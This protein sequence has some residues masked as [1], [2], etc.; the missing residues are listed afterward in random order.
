MRNVKSSLLLSCLSLLSFFT[1]ANNTGTDL[2]LSMHAVAG[3]MAGAA[4]TKPQEASSAVFGNPA[5]LAQ[6]K[7]VNYDFGA[8][9]LKIDEL[10][11]TQSTTLRGLGPNGSDL[12]FSNSSISSADNYILPTLASA[13][14]INDKAF[15]GLG[16][17]VDAGIGADF[18]NNP[19][20]LLGGAGEALVTSTVSLPLNIE[21]ISMNANVAGAYQVTPKL[22]LGASFTIGF[23]LA[24]F[25]TTG[26][27]QG[28]DELG[29]AL[30]GAVYD[31]GG[32][33][34]S[35][36]DTAFGYS[37]GATY[38]EPS[39]LAFS[40]ALK[41]SVKYKFE[42]I[43]YANT[44]A[45]RGFQDLPVEQPLEGIVGVAFD[46]YFADDLLIEADIIWKNWSSADT[47]QDLY[48]DQYLYVL[49]LQYKN[50]L[51]NLDFRFGYSYAENPLLDDAGSGIHELKGAG[52]LPLGFSASSIGLSAL[53]E[54]VVKIVQ[55]SLVPVIWQDTISAGFGYHLSERSSLN[56]FT[57]VSMAETDRRSLENIDA[58]LGTLNIDASSSHT[59]E[60]DKELSF[61]MSYSMTLP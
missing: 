45:F 61:G 27:T 17:E 37:L 24:Q 31:F 54:D 11:N 39:G 18:R 2:N 5:T 55:T 28:L 46:N 25:G 43:L 59:V 19:I 20:T 15:I 44:L 38:I 1:S 50:I 29:G 52:S 58:I 7:G 22:S 34:S 35:V 9:L 57:A 53:A 49:G 33:T 6:F 56:F 12:T 51:P 4:Y 36:H 42:N 41:S 16:L 40:V 47:Y 60:L 8:S 26:D 14:Q 3:S 48:D 21:L 10:K 30:G 13:I 23:G 32:T